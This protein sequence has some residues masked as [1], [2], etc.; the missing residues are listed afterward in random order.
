MLLGALL[1]FSSAAAAEVKI[2]PYSGAHLLVGQK[3]DLRVEVS[4]VMAGQEAAVMLDGKPV[5]G[6]IKT[7][8]A[9][10]TVEYTLR[11]RLAVSGAT[12]P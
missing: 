2:Y 10:G 9:A 11:R 4:G 7:N 3:F 5:A 8:S 6:L 12:T 1:A